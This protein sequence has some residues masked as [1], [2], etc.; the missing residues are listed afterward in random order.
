MG[1]DCLRQRQALNLEPRDE[2]REPIR[3]A[4]G[5]FYHGALAPAAERI[6]LR[7]MRIQHAFTELRL[8]N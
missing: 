3:R 6:I 7:Q 5:C 4:V 1:I 2:A 8:G